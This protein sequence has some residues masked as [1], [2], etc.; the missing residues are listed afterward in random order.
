MID[1]V[2]V[3]KAGDFYIAILPNSQ[4]VKF[5]QVHEVLSEEYSKH[6][7]AEKF[8]DLLEEIKKLEN[9]IS[10]EFE[11]FSRLIPLPGQCEVCEKAVA[12]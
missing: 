8:L 2:S 4:L 1:H 7:I 6:N 11:R 5:E 10:S 3:L 9:K 12:R